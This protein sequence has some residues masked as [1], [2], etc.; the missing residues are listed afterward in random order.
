MFVTVPR[1]RSYGYSRSNKQQEEEK[2]EPGMDSTYGVR[3]FGSVDSDWGSSSEA[4]EEVTAQADGSSLDPDIVEEEDTSRAAEEQEVELPP[5]AVGT[6]EEWT[7]T[8]DRSAPLPQTPSPTIPSPHLSLSHAYLHERER[9][10]LSEPSSPASFASMPSYMS[11]LSRTSSLAEAQAPLRSDHGVGIGM[12]GSEEL[13]LPTINV[14]QS[15]TAPRW[16]GTPA[17]G[18][19][20]LKVVLLGEQ[21]RMEAF[22]AEL[23]EMKEVVE[24]SS[25]SGSA[26]YAVVGGD[27]VVA[28]LSTE[29]SAEDVSHGSRNVDCRA[30][31]QILMHPGRNAT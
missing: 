28:L 20:G 3:S 11:S 17:Q 15:Q 2:P 4:R 27:N 8:V 31:G 14:S 12:G 10:N 18:E 25:G 29:S 16:R 26:E 24:L 13:V 21:A 6:T 22:I 1:M 30:S 5:V 9:D 23:S 19:K 7:P